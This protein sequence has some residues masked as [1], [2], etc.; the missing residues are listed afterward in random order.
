M[1]RLTFGPFLLDCEAR[2]LRRDGERV[3]LTGKTFDTLLLL[4]QN[5]GR[6]VKKD[7]LLSEV[8][9]S[10]T[11]EEANLTQTI[12]SLRKVL[13]D[14]PRDHRFIATVPGCGYQFVAPV[15]EMA[16]ASETTSRQPDRIQIRSKIFWRWP[17]W[18]MLT[19]A[20]F[21]I[22]AA[23]LLLFWYNE[24]SPIP[25]LAGVVQL[26][27][28]GRPKNELV[29]DGVRV[30]Y[31]SPTQQNLSHWRAYQVSINGGESQP[32]PPISQEV[33]PF[34]I[35]P[36]RAQLLLGPSDI[37]QS[38]DGWKNPGQ[39]WLQPLAGGPPSI[40]ALRA[41]DASW[42]PDGS[43]FIYASGRQIG[44]AHRD[45]APMRKFAD[46][47][48]VASGLRWSPSG[49]KIRFTLHYGIALK[50][51]AI[52]EIS[53]RGRKARPLFPDLKGQQ[54]DGEWTPDGSYYLFSRIDKGVSHLWAV[55]ESKPW[56]RRSPHPHVQLTTGPM[57]CLLP[58]P[59]PDGKKLLFY[60]MLERTMLLKY[61]A[62]SHRFEPFLPGVSG[63][64]LDFSADGKW[65]TYSSYP[66]HALWRAAAD[67]TQRLQLSPPDMTAMLPVI[68]PDGTRVAFVGGSPGQ[69]FS[70]FVV[71][72]NGGDL[73]RVVSTEPRGLVEPAWSPD[74]NSLALGAF[75]N[76]SPLYRFD[77]SN[78]RLSVLPGS[79]GLSS[80]HWSPDGQFIAALRSP[81]SALMLY[82][83]RSHRTIRVT[84][85]AAFNP[86][87][88]HDGQYL[89]FGSGKEDQSWY[90]LRIRDRKIERVV[91]LAEAGALPA[92]PSRGV[93]TWIDEWTGLAPDDSLLVAREAGSIELYSA[94]WVQH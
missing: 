18:L 2:T 5:R 73:Q 40:L 9:R 72:I 65:L 31:A 10:T 28:D 26:T 79:E 15:D 76:E 35:S 39:L 4:V 78:H 23:L 8:W 14:R 63:A 68:S 77:L 86:V 38:D 80:P 93:P 74:G 27:N 69:P 66:E 75:V 12:F 81:G 6:L 83:L 82:D 60:G 1:P 11:V 45:G 3:A 89:Y 49:D 64:H 48:G 57:Q 52:W 16:V 24:P 53:S 13:G 22:A 51:S 54:G 58:T 33:S 70:I 85:V 25:V 44:L 30:F 7:E 20:A 17:V 87:W 56:F 92:K 50:D 34:D 71:G 90:R 62:R 59:S 88:A 67:G 94:D 43:Q 42:S 36:D 37:R 19:S 84:D 21:C 55:P 47:P 61:D 46:L 41:Q 32:F 91:S 29:T